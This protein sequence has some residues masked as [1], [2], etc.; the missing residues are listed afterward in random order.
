MRLIKQIKIEGFRSIRSGTLKGMGSFT[1]FAGLNNSGKSNVLR[2]LNAFFSGYTDP[3]KPVDVDADYFRPDLRKRRKAKKIR[4][5]VTFVLSKT[6]KFRHSLESVEQFLGRGPFRI[7][8]EWVRNEVLPA[9]YL[10]D[11]NRL[12][13]EGRDKVDKFL[14]L[15]NFRYI[16][17]RV[18][19]IDV[20][21][22]EHRALRDVLTRQLARRATG[23]EAA[24]KAIAETSG[25]LLRAVVTRFHEAC[26]NEGE[27]RL[28]TPTS[29]SDMVFAFG[30]RLAQGDV[31]IEDAFQ[32]SGIQS[33]L[34]LE[35]LFL[36]D[37]DYG[38]RFG[39]RQAAIWAVEEPES[40]LHSSL[41]A[42]VA[43]Y[44]KA[45]SADR[46][47]RLQVLC[48]THS[49]LMIQYADETIVVDRANNETSFKEQDDPREAIN[50]LSRV[51]VSRWT[52]PLLFHP[53]DPLI[54]VEGKYDRA[55][56]LAA[57]K[58]IVPTRKVRISYLEMLG[59]G[60]RT[61]GTDLYNYVRDNAQAIKCRRRD[62]PVI[63]VLDWDARGK[64]TAYEKL[65]ASDDPFKVLAWTDATF[66]PKIGKSFHGI[67]RHYSNRLIKKAEDDGARI[68]WAKD[69]ICTVEREDY[70]KVKELLHEIVKTDLKESDL[71]NARPFIE[72]VLRTVGALS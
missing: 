21:R 6:F 66:N 8:K 60:N 16:P 7:T 34:M 38:Q 58:F 25:K 64:A 67:E 5:T 20:I 29:W 31:E 24:F 49:D 48:T 43:S 14:Q 15:I 18:L 54:L 3:G 65:F 51:G 30:Y 68:A 11:G 44:L 23:H 40:S 47:S 56:F 4:I 46:A 27:P 53:L 39:W 72:E 32:G 17:N 26:P 70:G 41:E 50:H 22:D 19:P 71:A 52:H 69:G 1:A 61:G 62:S 12:D 9:Y 63:V 59:D 13:L 28:A 2:A 55:F 45:I 33:F 57:L 42:R 10:N 35:T 36:I 37:R